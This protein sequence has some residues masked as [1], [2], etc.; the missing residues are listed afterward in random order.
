MLLIS[1]DTF[2][3]MLHYVSYDAIYVTGSI[4]IMSYCIY[5]YRDVIYVR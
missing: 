3:I 4:N 2:N 1:F 5:I